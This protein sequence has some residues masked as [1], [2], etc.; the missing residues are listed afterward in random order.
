MKFTDLTQKTH[1]GFGSAL[2]NLALL[3][4]TF[5]VGNA[6]TSYYSGR[7]G[8]YARRGQSYLVDQQL[9]GVSKR[10]FTPKK[11]PVAAR[12]QK[13]MAVEGVGISKLSA[14][15]ELVIVDQNIKDYQLFSR[16]ARPG[17]EVVEI[18]KDAQGLQTLLTIL[19]QYE[20]LSAVHLMSH[21]GSGKLTLGGETVS[22]STLKHN[23]ETF[24]ILN[25]AI[26][27]GGDF[28]LYGCEL[29]KGDEGD[30][31]LEIIKGNTHVDVAAS[32]DLT[33][34][35]DYQG[36]WDLEI[37]KGDIEASPVDGSIALKDLTGVLQ[38]A[39]FDF[40]S[41]TSTLY[42]AT[43]TQTVGSYTMTFD[44]SFYQGSYHGFHYGTESLATGRNG[45]GYATAVNMSISSNTFT[46]NTM[47][48]LSLLSG[49]QTIFISTP[50]GGVNFTVPYN[51]FAT[52]DVSTLDAA[53]QPKFHD[54]SDLDVTLVSGGSD[55]RLIFDNIDVS[56]INTDN[57]PTLTSVSIASDNP[58]SDHA[59]VG[60][61]V[62]VSFIASED[63]Q[64]NPAVSIFGKTATVTRIGN[65]WKNWEATYY[66]TGSDPEGMVTFVITYSDF[67]LNSGTPVSTTTNATNVVFDNTPPTLTSVTMTSNNSNGSTYGISGDIVTI[68]IGAV[69]NISQPIVTFFGN[70][71][72]VLGLD[73]N[74]TATYT[75]DGTEPDGSVVFNIVFE[76]IAGN[77]GS[78]VTQTTNDIYVDVDNT[79]P[80]GYTIDVDQANANSSTYTSTSFTF[81]AA[82]LS[83]TYDYTVSSSGGGTPIVGSG[84][85]SS[86]KQSV[87]GIDVST[88][89]EGTLTYSVTLTD[90]HGNV[91]LAV[92]STLVYDITIPVITGPAN[93]NVLEG[94]THVGTYTVNEA[95]DEGNSGF[96]S[97][98]DGSFFSFTPSTGELY[99][100]SPPDFE[101]P[102]DGD[103][104]NIYDIT[105]YFN[106]VAGN[107]EYLNL[108]I[109]V[110]DKADEVPPL[111]T[112]PSGG[113]G[114]ATSSKSIP[115]NSTFV[116]T[117]TADETVT[118]QLNKGQDESFFSI[119]S[120]TGTLSF[121]NPPD[122]ENPAD[123]PNSG[124][125]T[126]EVIVRATDASSNFS[127]QTVTVT[128]TDVDE[129]PPVITGPSGGAGSVTSAITIPENTTAVHTFSANE[130]VTWSLN[131]GED[132]SKFS[133]ISS[134]GVLTFTTAPDFEAPTDGATSG[135]N[136]YIVV[137]SATD[138]LSNASS[139]T[140]TVTIS[141]AN[142]NAPN[143]QNPGILSIA[144]NSPV[145]T[146]VVTMTATDADGVSTFTWSL[147][148]TSMP[149]VDGDGQRAF[150]INSTTGVITV[151]DSGDLDFETN[152][153]FSPYVIVSDGANAAGTNIS[154]SILDVDEVPPTV[155]ISTS[156][157]TPTNSSSIPVTFTFSE[158]VSGFATTDVT[159]SGGTLGGLS[160]ANNISFTATVTPSITSGNVSLQVVAGSYTDLSGNAGVASAN[161]LITVDQVAPTAA[162]STSANNPTNLPSI[163]VTIT[164]SEAVNGLELSDFTVTNGTVTNLGGGGSSYAL[165]LNPVSDGAVT[166]SAPAGSVTDQAGNV[167]AVANFTINSDRTVPT[168]VISSALSTPTKNAS[169]PVTIAF[170]ESVTGLEITDFQ[171][172]NGSLNTLSGAGTLYTVNLVATAEGTVSLNL[173]VNSAQDD[174]GNGNNVS[175]NYQHIYD[176]TPPVVTVTA[177]Q[178]VDDTPPLSGTVS[179]PLATVNVTVNGQT[180]SATVAG[181]N[182]NVANDVINSL[183]TG[184]YDVIAT[185]TDQAGNSATDN[186]TNELEIL[187]GPPA[188]VSATEIAYFSFKAN[189][190]P[191]SG[192]TSYQLD[193]ASDAAF[194]KM[195]TN[196]NNLSTTETTVSV[197]TGVYYGSVYYYRVRAVYPSSVVSENSNTIQV[198]TPVDPNTVADSVALLKIYDALGGANWT[199]K[200]NWR[201]NQPLRNWTDITFPLSGTRV[202]AINLSSNN[203]RGSLPDWGTGLE[204]VTTFNLRTNRITT[205]PSTLSSFANTQFDLRN[206]R[207]QFGTLEPVAS[208]TTLQFNPQD[209]V[210][211]QII[212]LQQIG[213]TYT[214]DRTIT[215]SNNIYTF[216]KLANGATTQLTGS[217]PTRSLSITNFDNEGSYF[218]TVTNSAVPGLTLT[219]QAIVL[220]VSSLQRDEL[221]LKAIYNA[222][223]GATWIGAARNW[224]TNTSLVNGGNWEGVTVTSNRV[225]ALRL[226]GVG[227]T[228]ALPSDITDIRGLTVINL[229]GNAITSL[230]D[231]TILTNLTSLNVSAN[232]LQFG[233]LE[234]NITVPGFQ[235]G[236]QAR[237]GV[238]RQDTVPVNSAQT[239]T[240]QTTGQN[241]VYQWYLTN[242][243][244]NTETLIPG[245]TST[246]YEIPSIKYESMG[247]YRVKITNTKVPNITIEGRRQ[248]VL[249]FGE[250]HFKGI[251][252]DGLPITVGTGYALKNQGKGRPFDSAAVVKVLNE[253]FF[254]DSLVLGDYLIALE[255]DTSKYL[256]T[257]YKNTFLW[258]EA[259]TLLLRDN[260]VDVLHMTAKP[261]K[262][263]PVFDTQVAGFVEADLPDNPDDEDRISSRRK[264]QKAGCSMRKFK[265]SGRTDQDGQWELVAYVQTNDQGQF[266][267]DY[268]PPGLYRFNIEYP[269]IPMDPNSFVEFEISEDDDLTSKFVLEAFVTENGIEVERI[270]PL[271]YRRN[272]FKNLEVYPNPADNI[273]RL[274]Y[275][276]LLADEVYVELID[277]TGKVLIKQILQRGY[278]L[279]YEL[280]TESLPNGF[281]VL[282]FVDTSKADKIVTTV[283][284]VVRH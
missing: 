168:V 74:W 211:T 250:I 138:A 5:T 134:T 70:S 52:F 120:S 239:V 31:F 126:Y 223:G 145:G 233:D 42:S 214:L 2:L 219:T 89:N 71:G 16:L 249:A 202:T 274:S 243:V 283:K 237:V 32:D 162:F 45:I 87:T 36:D 258:E 230:P 210:G 28:L 186:T 170:S 216:F 149:D 208:L 59:R 53:D 61:E 165:N 7:R 246:S 173:P 248:T 10:F 17:V 167:N 96:F 242:P 66:P 97:E 133:I 37:R 90:S 267:F 159:V 153:T 264:V 102:L 39:T 222:M 189:W 124:T 119:N 175:N 212:T 181:N 103:G 187:G 22:S 98:L 177:L 143:I 101:T 85:V 268:L 13:P 129:I 200:S 142:D 164:F 43:V 65:D 81:T 235:Y 68:S 109:T 131:G 245:A 25:K 209:S 271:G 169:I 255:G 279:E 188:T 203:L 82:E 3:T 244:N 130:S 247:L 41:G 77:A 201:S 26:V 280:S 160:T 18:P 110:T 207:L 125:N 225:T 112:G 72:N 172:S 262:L 75:L 139:Q 86:A 151:N 199:R 150:T 232:N 221:A 179:D 166:L 135:T 30:E 67:T 270:A 93:P 241:N 176:L 50:K 105:I 183:A 79:I 55:L 76:D 108:L 174:A 57:I 47:Q 95:I 185:A 141:N 40:E 155:V 147:D 240:I 256:P 184:V 23:I 228:G 4:G 254:F 156:V 282:N 123:G 269:G 215:G 204:A 163:P 35:A 161:F 257:Y 251:G 107:T 205:V 218:A 140:V 263:P 193:V 197:N 213:A 51:G 275:S 198:I 182:W 14:I 49:G 34:N 15:R 94:D 69:E 278:D 144:E 277:M 266:V 236:T 99:F 19:S 1:R 157:S 190:L 6:A 100:I 180:I 92:T 78:D 224:P 154:I 11:T 80:S 137:V 44:G 272:Y 265:A 229:S 152:P 234:R 195:L 191:R 238:L 111:I 281:Y 194:T 253:E 192:V 106:D 73:K 83:T 48:I 104:D 64:E 128:I 27:P 178:T 284:V 260:I 46:L 84:P 273:L 33:G 117:F 63:L 146:T 58:V 113:S 38:A 148:A 261:G 252:S 259:D 24:D 227:L 121:I 122:F 29:G 127:E 231:M 158:Q 206:N 91:G 20:G 118:W 21:A 12:D 8:T 115:E 114:S 171:V 196:F 136:T 276:K 54:V 132:V 116:H 60:N 62:K 226:P 9:S 56:D 88:L 220:R 217:G